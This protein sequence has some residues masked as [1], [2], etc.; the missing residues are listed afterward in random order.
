MSVFTHLLCPRCKKRTAVATVWDKQ[1]SY[2]CNCMGEETLILKITLQKDKI[3]Q[4]FVQE[5]LDK[6]WKGAEK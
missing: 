1:I 5:N 2:R 6:Y 3:T 4:K